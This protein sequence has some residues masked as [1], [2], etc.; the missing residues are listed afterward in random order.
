MD[1]LELDFNNPDAQQ[2]L[3][4]DVLIRK[5]SMESLNSIIPRDD[6]PWTDFHRIN[7]NNS[8]VIENPE[9]EHIKHDKEMDPDIEMH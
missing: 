1:P 4:E 8:F 3:Y 2:T 9:P 5:K 6:D 7:N